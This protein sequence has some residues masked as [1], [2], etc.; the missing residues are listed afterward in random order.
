[1]PSTLPCSISTEVS[2]R[3]WPLPDTP[4][5]M[6]QRWESLLFTHWP[7]PVEVLR[8]LIPPGLTLDTFEGEG[9]IGVVPFTMSF[10]L[11]GVSFC[12]EAF[13]EINVRT[14]VTIGDKPGVYFFSLD[15]ASLFS[16]MMA[17]TL[18]R[19]P[20]HHARMQL[21]KQGAS[22]HYDSH[23]RNTV[24]GQE[25]MFSGSY[26]PTGPVTYAQPGTLEHWLTER[27]CLYTVPPSGQV[28]HVDIHHAPWPLQPEEA[29]IQQNTMARVKGIQLPDIPPIL[30]Y[31]EQLEVV[32]WPLTRTPPAAR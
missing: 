14:Y 23:R 21:K 29:E 30:H 24:S 7:L 3:P 27:Y 4:W 1:M 13:H 11:R 12:R 22:I 5:I 31:A 26:A 19:L 9:W 32:S 17:R 18:F 15:A 28:K 8:P 25:A 16:V 6:A 20:Y 10:S 2:H